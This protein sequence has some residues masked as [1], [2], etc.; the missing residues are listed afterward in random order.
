MISAKLLVAELMES[1]SGFTLT[2]SR[3]LLLQLL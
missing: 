2:N 3:A 1:L